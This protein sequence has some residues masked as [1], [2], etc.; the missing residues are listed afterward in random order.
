MSCALGIALYG[1]NPLSGIPNPMEPV[2]SLFGRIAQLGEAKAGETIGY[3]AAL[4]LTRRTRYVTVSTG[5][6]DGYFR[7]LGSADGHAGARRI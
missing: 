5:Y 1:G 2:I 6:A 4:H 7:L 3:G